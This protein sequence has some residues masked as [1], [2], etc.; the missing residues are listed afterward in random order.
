MLKTLLASTSLSLVLLCIPM[1][2]VG[3]FSTSGAAGLAPAHAEFGISLG[4]GGGD[5]DE[6]GPTLGFGL[7][8]GD[9]ED[10]AGGDDDEGG[11][12]EGDD[13]EEDD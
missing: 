1:G 12:D 11:N 3:P 7:S 2:S 5:D 4:L 10:D 9:D 13:E 8:G 6:G